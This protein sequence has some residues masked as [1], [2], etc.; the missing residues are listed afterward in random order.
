MRSKYIAGTVPTGFLSC[1]VAIVFPELLNHKDVARKMGMSD[2]TSAGF[3]SLG[4][5]DDKYVICL[6]GI[7]TSLGIVSNPD[8]THLVATALGFAEHEWTLPL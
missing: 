1:E 6:Y 8:D 4:T 5:L 3:V 2:I 7:S